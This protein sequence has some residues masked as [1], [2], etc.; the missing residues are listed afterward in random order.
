[1]P[2]PLSEVHGLCCGLLCSMSS[3]AA[4]TRWFTE[5]LD[6]AQISS[7]AVASKAAQLKTLDDWF[8][9]TL[10]S[11]NDADLE[12]A[13]A[14]PDETL[15]VS[16]RNRALGDFCGGFTYGLGLALSKRGEKPL[17]SDTREIIEDFQAIESA[18]IDEPYSPKGVISSSD[19]IEQQEV[20]Y[21]ELLEYV[22]VGVL[23]ILEELR[24]IT[25][26]AQ[27]KPS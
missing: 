26:V 10:T 25:P 5:M 1:M 14:M 11:L 22:R 12:F 19:D 15:P 24:P 16:I 27:V 20:T 13:P 8:M 17:P 6:A 3:T 23:L 2:L 9:A 4:K 7:D 21:N 18:D